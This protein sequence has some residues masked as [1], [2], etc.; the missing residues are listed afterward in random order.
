M[1]LKRVV[2]TGIGVVSPLGNSVASFIDGLETGKSSVCFMEEWTKYKGMRSHVAAPAELKDEKKIPRQFR[3]SMGRMSIFA[4]QA[5]E[6]AVADSGLMPSDMAVGRTGCIIGSTM[7][8]AK[9]INDVF[10]I[11]LPERDLTQLPSS[12]FFQCM[13]H[14]ATANVAH[15]LGLTGYTMATAAACASALQAIGIGYDLIR[16]DRQDIFLC[17]GAE[18][19]HPTVTGSFDVLFATSVKYNQTPKKTPR[20]FDKDRDGLVCG[21]GSGILVLEEYEHAVRRNA[22]I[23]AEIT[24]YSTFGSAAHMSQSDKKSMMYCMNE[25][26]KDSNIAPKQIDYINAHA[27]GTQQGDKEEAEAIKGIFGDSV[28]VSSLKGYIG[29]TLGAS[30][31]IELIASLI[32]MKNGIIYPTLNLDEISP[33]CEGVNHVTQPV[34]KEINTILKNCF[35]FGGINA[36]MI[37]KRV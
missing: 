12:M 18:E 35:A 26:L 25:V 4:A 19:L 29:H 36:S 11:M 9:S 7:G 10:E 1:Q 13:S 5:A 3:R 8:S 6:R 24:G 34:K 31:A 20:P 17:G 28:P 33:D 14:T 32:M 15:Y 30:G 27:T 23:Y 37:C 22:K 21:E 16:L 2:I